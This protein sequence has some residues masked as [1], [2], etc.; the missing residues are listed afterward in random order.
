[1]RDE[2]VKKAYVVDR[3]PG[4]VVVVMTYD[5]IMSMTYR[6]MNNIFFS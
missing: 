2:I 5:H 4:A 6:K 1:M 3:S